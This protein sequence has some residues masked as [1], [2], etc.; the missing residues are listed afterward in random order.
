MA[1]YIVHMQHI[2]FLLL[3]NDWNDWN[4][5][6]VGV[7]DI[8]NKS[9]FDWE[10]EHLV[11]EKFQMVTTQYFKLELNNLIKNQLIN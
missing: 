1:F 4:D 7:V 2:F 3:E 11:F 10:N 5:F 8:G 6:V 9:G